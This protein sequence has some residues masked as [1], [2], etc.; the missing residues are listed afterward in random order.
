[1]QTEQV[2]MILCGVIVISYLFSIMSRKLRVPSVLLLMFSGIIGRYV[3]D[4]YQ[5]TVELP[6]LVVEGLGVVGLIMIVLEAGL[7][8]KLTRDKLPLI[9]K[10]FFSASVIFFASAALI[11]GILV[12][13]LEESL[14][15][16][17]VYAIPM[18][19]ISSAIVIPSLHHMT[20]AKKEFLVY[21]ASFSDIV[22]I[23]VFNYFVAEEILTWASAGIFVGG[24]VGSVV[25]SIAFSVLLFLIMTNTKLNIKFFLIISLLILLYAS[26]KLLHLP[27]LLI[28]LVFGLMINNWNLVKLP[29]FLGTYS[30]KQVHEIHE[31]LHSITAELSFLVRTFFFILF[32]YTIQIELVF[33]AD[34]ALVGGM[35]VLA[36]LLVR[37]FYLRV[38]MKANLLPE[39]FFMPRGL[40]TIVL[41]YKIPDVLKL[42]SFNESII[43]FVILA[44]STLMMLGSIFYKGEKEPIQEEQLFAD[45]LSHESLPTS[46][47][48]AKTS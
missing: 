38:F 40:I 14:I 8:L 30:K 27:S 41:F 16:C 10:S 17:I 2:L 24:I 18:S 12:Y 26:G 15:Q 21:E 37:L 3:T 39:L 44:T 5:L 20:N 31:I 4:K 1:M 36:L 47:T 7:D 13:W 33:Q 48:V 11:T 19:I 29:A 35:I 42:S 22:G 32:G 34:V 25:L 45:N 28:I 43:A 46:E 23:I 9:R 6:R